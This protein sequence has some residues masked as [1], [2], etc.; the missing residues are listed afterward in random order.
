MTNTTCR[1]ESKIGEPFIFLP[2]SMIGG[3][4]STNETPIKNRVFG[5]VVNDGEEN[6]ANFKAKAI[7]LA[8][9][10]FIGDKGSEF[11]GYGLIHQLDNEL[12]LQRI[13]TNLL[14]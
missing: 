8:D 10:G 14:N 11:P 7:F 4:G 2:D 5:L 12:L 3:W 13:L 6:Y 9:S 1:I